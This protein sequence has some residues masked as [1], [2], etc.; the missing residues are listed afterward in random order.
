MK[1]K[2]KSVKTTILILAVAAAAIFIAK[3]F[4]FASTRSATRIGYVGN[5]GW[6]SWSGRYVMLDGTM[7]KS[8]HPKGDRL[9]IVVETNEGTI[10]IQI[11]DD[12]GS[13][14]FD[15]ENIGT[16]SFDVE[17]SGKAVVRIKAKGHRGSFDIA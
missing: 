11:K 5:E 12:Q 15:E 3:V 2:P 9:H 16:E 17:T 8:V 7:E 13:M 14:L 10:S 1:V 4:G 6:N